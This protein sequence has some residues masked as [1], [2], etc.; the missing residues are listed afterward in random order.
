MAETAITTYAS[1]DD[2]VDR[3]GNNLVAQISQVD[4]SQ[5]AGTIDTTRVTTALQWAASEIHRM[6]RD[7]P[8]S[9]P[10][11]FN[12]PE[13]A[14]IVIEWNCVLALEWLYTTRGLRD[15][16]GDG[17]KFTAM[18]KETRRQIRAAKCGAEPITGSRRWP[19]PSGAVASP[20]FQVP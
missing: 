13:D 5:P 18:G 7:G 10:L 16:D 6:F 11:T 9:L 19:G 4:S 1:Q 17:N 14:N 12:A 2:L 15:D 20:Q 8:Y 3:F